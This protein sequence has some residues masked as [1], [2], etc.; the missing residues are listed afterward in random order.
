MKFIRFL[1]ISVCP[2]FYI[3]KGQKAVKRLM[4]AH[5]RHLQTKRLNQMK[6]QYE[7][8]RKGKETTMPYFHECPLCGCNLDPGES[9][10]CQS[11]HDSILREKKKAAPCS[12]GIAYRP[13]SLKNRGVA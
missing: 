3:T 11:G 10:D 12:D 13:E 9:W 6:M 7:I 2:C 5:E 4:R 1:L 8:I